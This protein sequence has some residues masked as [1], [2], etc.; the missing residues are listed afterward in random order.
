MIYSDLLKPS[1]IDLPRFL[2]QLGSAI[3]LAG[4]ECYLV[5]GWV[6][7]QLLNIPSKD[8]DL[9]VH[10][11][12]APNLQELL[13][14]F[15]HVR[16]IGK[17]F[18]VFQITYDQCTYDIALPRKEI[19]VG[20]GHKGFSIEFDP[21]LD[22]AKAS[23][24]RDFT[25]NAMGYQIPQGLLHDPHGGLQDLRNKVLR[26]VSEAFSEDPLRALRAVQ[27]AAR[28]QLNIAEDTQ[29]LCS[30]QPLQELPPERIFEEFRK[31]LLKSPRPSLALEWLKKLDLLH[32]FPELEA[33]VGVPQ[34][35]TW[36]PE[37]DVWTHNNMVLDEAAKIRDLMIDTSTA[38]VQDLSHPYH[39]HDL[40]F[41]R[42]ALMLGALC[43]DLGKAVCTKLVE[44]K[45]RS[46]GHEG[47]GEKPTRSFLSRLTRDQKL[48]DEVVS[49]V[50]EHLKPALLYNERDSIK[51][52]AIRRLSLRV[53]IPALLRVA[54]A[55]HFG[56]TTPDALAREFPAESWLLSQ[57]EELGVLMEKP[58]PLLR[59]DYLK[60]LGF[61]PGPGM[62]NLIRECFELQLE[63]KITTAEEAQDWAKEKIRSL[64]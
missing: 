6:R 33:L 23:L 8:Y 12:S 26:H 58:K 22:F 42:L 41:D 50:R 20:A 45:W 49:L 52:A 40:E 34:D 63:G 24:R 19:K 48:H 53:N 61:F 1:S 28:F 21:S 55:D 36:H 39:S 32:F 7:D 29:K 43:H 38:S 30:I 3:Q 59:G 47:L 44:G 14:K 13:E 9:E 35:P 60:E 11:I 51:P 37:G 64:R 4:G 46:P 31:F 10:G 15:G 5:G 54:K 27:F 57:C 17:S 18:G 62:G 2:I 16:F 25:L 56:R